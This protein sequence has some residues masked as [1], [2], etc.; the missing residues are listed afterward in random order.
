M[1]KPTY[2]LWTHDFESKEDM[3]IA[4][5]R[6]TNLGFRVVTL[7][8]GSDSQSIQEGIKSL[9]RNHIYDI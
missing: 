1:N 2:Y 5:E 7:H 8:A 9:I 6:Y 3:L 4:K